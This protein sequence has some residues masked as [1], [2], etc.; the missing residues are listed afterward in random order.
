MPIDSQGKLIIFC[1][2][3]G[4]GDTTVIITPENNVIIIDAYKTE[5]I[6]TFLEEIGLAAQD[7]IKHLVVSHPHNDHYSAVVPLLNYFT[8]EELTLSSLRNYEED[9]PGY[10]GIINMAA[11]QG[12]PMN[13]L[14]GYKQMHPDNSPFL[15]DDT[16][17]FELL[18][19]SNQFIENLSR[20]GVLE[21]NH[22]SIVARLFWRNFRMIIAGDAQMENWAHF[23]QEQMLEDRPTV[24]RSAH[25]G[26]ANGT[27]YERIK[28][29]HPKYVIV[30]SDPWGRHELPDLIGC[31]TFLTYE[32]HSSKPLIA[33]THMTGSIKIE[34]PTSGRPKL[35]SFGEPINAN[36]DLANQSRLTVNNNPTN[37]EG[38]ATRKLSPSP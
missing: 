31:T 25:H 35:F 29:L 15:D 5:K 30:S 22:Y 18:G 37:W 17:R 8:V 7:K 33:L 38:L 21:I 2:N 26:S 23:D 27:Q 11:T 10:I 20:A 9:T 32:G 4:Q 12:I 19:P 3:V 1:I 16:L 28:R 14:S 6:I 36:I 13:F 24:L 34:V